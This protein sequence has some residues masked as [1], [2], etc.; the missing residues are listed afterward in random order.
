MDFR[1]GAR[2]SIVFL[3]STYLNI[4]MKDLLQQPRP[5]NLDPAIKLS[6]ADGFGFPSDHAQA[7]LVVWTGMAAWF[8]KSWFW[9]MAA[10][11]IALIGFSRIYLGVHFPTDVIAGWAIGIVFLCLYLW[12]YKRL[13]DRLKHRGLLLQILLVF[14]LSIVLLV[15]HPTKD[16][17]AISATIA[18]IGVGAALNR[19]YIYFSAHGPPGQRVLRFFIGIIIL[20]FLFVAFNKVMVSE[21]PSLNMIY[22]FLTYLLVGLWVSLGG[23]WL[24][25]LL[26]IAPSC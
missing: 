4:G 19:R 2:L 3:L 22:R 6:E 21:S 12:L 16:T 14:T 10:F 24:F 26:R 15:V 25:R 11:L 8:R 13:E 7:S 9:A 23:P 18:G 20:I 17:T 1:F 5:F